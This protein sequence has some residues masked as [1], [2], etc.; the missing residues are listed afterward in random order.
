MLHIQ[1]QPDGLRQATFTS[2][3]QK[4]GAPADGLLPNL[5][6]GSIYG[7]P[8]GTSK[9][10]Y[11]WDRATQ[12]FVVDN[13]FLLPIDAPDAVSS[14]NQDDVGSVFSSTFSSDQIRIGRFF[15]QPDGSWKLDEETY[16]PFTHYR[17]FNAFVDGDYVWGYGEILVRLD[18]RIKPR[19]AALTAPIIRQVL[20]GSK[21]LYGGDPI[22]GQA[23]L[24]LPPATRALSFQFATLAYGAT[25]STNYQ[26]L[27]EGADK[28]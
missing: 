18:T 11:R 16:R 24:R 19:A 13:R 22:P 10:L 14:V 20:S 26:Y 1:V 4:E 21:I 2:I 6:D 12:K 25:E 23:D 7:N 15:K 5:I 27:L 28:D 17:L 8:G 3:T 9:G